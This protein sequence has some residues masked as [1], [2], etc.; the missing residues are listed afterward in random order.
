MTKAE[1][2]TTVDR[3]ARESDVIAAVRRAAQQEQFLEVVS[4]D[5]ARERFARHVST[6]PLPGEPIALLAALGRV[7]A[8]DL[9]APIDVPPFDRSN[10]DGF[11]LRA[12]ETIGASDMAPRRL[13]LNREVIACGHLPTLAVASGTATAIATGGMVPRGADAVIMIEQTELSDDESGLAITIRR[14]VAAGQFVSYAGSDMARGETVLRRG[15]VI[16][17]REIGMLA[18]CGIAE[19]SVVRRPRIA[20]L[21]TGDELTVPGEALPPA[22]VYDSNGAILAAAIAEAGGVPVPFGAFRDDEDALRA[23]VGQALD[24][25]DMVI[26]SGGTSKGAGDLSHRV[27]TGFG[28]PGIIVHGVALKPGKPLC[29][30]VVGGKPVAILPG[31]PTSA[32]FTFHAFIAPMIRARA[33]LPPEK[34]AHV[35]ADIPVPIASELGRQ[36]FVLIALVEGKDG[37]LAFPTAKGSGS[38]TSFSQADGFVTIDALTAMRDAGGRD[39]VTLIG[40]STQMP[41][42]V[43]MGSHCIGLDV[44]LGAMADQGL[45]AL[46][47]DRVPG[48]CGCRGSWRVRPGTGPSR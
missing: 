4:A 39:Q 2:G 22:S 43:I 32:I 17:S 20:I 15:T 11:A 42:L 16:G 37:P 28:E 7:L 34:A 33:G 41:D 23:A 45:R 36:E 13:S 10:V 35:A 24:D 46:D 29:L 3:D 14:A 1:T 8:A 12:A 30:A 38:V 31:F 26:L 44:V 18:A 48:W 19:L 6:A 40:S 5:E 21:S 27:I 9:Q 47:C 25:C